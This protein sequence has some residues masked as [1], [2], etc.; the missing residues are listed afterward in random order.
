M[1]NSPEQQEQERPS[2][3]Q[4]SNSVDSRP[5]S[6]RTLQRSHSS[7][8]LATAVSWLPRMFR[9]PAKNANGVLYDP[10]ETLGSEEGESQGYGAESAPVTKEEDR[11]ARQR[12]EVDDEEEEEEEERVAGGQS[13]LG[14]V[15]RAM[16]DEVMTGEDENQT[17][18]SREFRLLA[19]RSARSFADF[20][21]SLSVL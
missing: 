18:L 19:C 21:Y 13:M 9:S 14:L 11:R 12:R 17:D 20:S 15:E 10:E 1:E 2:L 7:S 4:T 5:T 16:E 8:V 3:Q 6:S